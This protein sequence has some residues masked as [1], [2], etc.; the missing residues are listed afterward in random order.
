MTEHMALSSDV[1]WVTLK[2]IQF[3]AWQCFWF[4]FK[5]DPPHRQ[6]LRRQN[7]RPSLWTRVWSGQFTCRLQARI[8]TEKRRSEPSNENLEPFL[9]AFTS[10]KKNRFYNTAIKVLGNWQINIIIIDIYVDF[11]YQKKLH[12][13]YNERGGGESI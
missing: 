10:R 9:L 2:K 8:P 13:N 11:K 7:S 1:S 6:Y 3:Q 5:L 4:F 12:D